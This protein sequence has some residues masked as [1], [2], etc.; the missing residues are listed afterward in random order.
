M[1]NKGKMM[2]TKLGFKLLCEHGRLPTRAHDGDAGMDLYA[3]EGMHFSPGV[4]G[5]VGTSIAPVIPPGYELQVR[6]RS[7]MAFKHGVTIVNAPG[8]IDAGYTGEIK[9]VLVNHGRKTF[10]V[11]AG[12]RIAQ[13]V[14][15]K[16][17]PCEIVEVEELPD[18][19]RGAGGFGSS[20]R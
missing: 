8:T 13:L 18:T 16:V 5:V 7:G 14:F 3:S 17:E 19:E 4:M 6:P 1:L 20:G 12:D 10:S 2:T 11:K 9:V 15:A